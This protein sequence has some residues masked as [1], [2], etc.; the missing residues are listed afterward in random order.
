MAG[1]L[2]DFESG[3]LS[4]GFVSG[5]LTF[6]KTDGTIDGQ[7]VKYTREGTTDGIRKRSVCLSDGGGNF[8]FRTDLKESSDWKCCSPQTNL[9]GT[10]KSSQFVLGAG[11][12]TFDYSG[13]GG[14]VA[15]CLGSNSSKCKKNY[16]YSSSNIMTQGRFRAAD[17]MD[18]VGKS[19]HFELVD[20]GPTA[21]IAV[22]NIRFNMTGPTHVYAHLS[23][24]SF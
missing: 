22:D 7:P 2:V 3:G 1:G 9:F 13:N 5:G 21:Y 24:I 19:V 10:Y 8:L 20:D 16:P 23:S 6:T 12:I 11:E 4:T 18:W 17:L 14:Y 15:L